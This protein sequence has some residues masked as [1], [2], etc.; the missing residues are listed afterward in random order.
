MEHAHVVNGAEFL[1]PER[2]ARE[3]GRRM[4]ST[5]G[6]LVVASCRSGT[7]L[8]QQVV[9][10]YRELMEQYGGS[11][12]VLYLA[13]IDYQF[14]DGETGVRLAEH[15]G[16]YDVFVFQALYDPASPRA[17]DCNYMAFLIAARTFREHGANHVTG[18]LPYLAYA[19]QDKPTRF[20]RE[21]TTARLLADVSITAGIDRLISW[22]PHSG[23]TR[24]FYGSLPVS[25]LEALGLF[26][27]EFERFRER[28]DVVC[29][30]PDLG[31]SKFI[32]YFGRTLRLP[33]A[34]ASKYRPEP[35]VSVVTEII[36]D[37]SDKRV[38][39]VLDDMISGGGTLYGVVRELVEKKGI[40]EVYV[41]SSHALCVGSALDRLNELHEHYGLRQV[42]VTDSVP[43]TDTFRSLPFVK[44][45]SLADPL[46][47]AI[48]RIHY[49][50]SLSDVFERPILEATRHTE[51]DAP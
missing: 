8:A 51:E 24:G 30:A 23:Q 49:H 22:H 36:G 34:F 33:V 4:V 42:V 44:V 11:A 47:W 16:G 20:Q 41:G 10:R 14:T 43:Q 13:D 1:T 6:R 25:F 17:I 27:R 5:R 12:E 32:T 3:Q 40:E 37:L 50:R 46:A 21:P 31:A 19:R 38:A 7:A 48:N 39:I 15:V 2:L 35:E 26:V 18:V 28:S 29:V 9:A 45:V